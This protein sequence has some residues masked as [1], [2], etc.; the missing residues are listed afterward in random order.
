MRLTTAMQP[1]VNG[2]DHALASTLDRPSVGRGV[3]I[4]EKALHGGFGS[5]TTR[6]GT[7]DAIG[8]DQRRAAMAFGAIRQANAQGILIAGFDAT[9]S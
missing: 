4:T 8:N 5:L 1:M 3:V 9:L 2:G 6:I 7:A